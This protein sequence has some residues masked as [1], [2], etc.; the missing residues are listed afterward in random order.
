MGDKPRCIIVGRYPTASAWRL[1]GEDEFEC[2]WQ[3]A[4]GGRA[5]SY[6]TVQQL[7]KRMGYDVSWECPVCGCRPT[8]A[9]V[10]G[11]DP[12]F[13]A[14]AARL[15]ADRVLPPSRSDVLEAIEGLGGSERV[16]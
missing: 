6:E 11:H 8:T 1:V 16:M 10:Q 14:V 4:P 13:V 9:C 3:G 5:S 2:I 7:A 15:A 12:M